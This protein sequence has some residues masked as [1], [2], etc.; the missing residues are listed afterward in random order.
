MMLTRAHERGCCLTYDYVTD[1]ATELLGEEDLD[2]ISAL[3]GMVTSRPLYSGISHSSALHGCLQH[4]KLWLQG[5]HEP[6][7]SGSALT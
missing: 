3:G 2:M 4:A 1:D 6:I 7:V 5:A